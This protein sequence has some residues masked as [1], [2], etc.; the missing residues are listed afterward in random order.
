MQTIVGELKERSSASRAATGSSEE[1]VS[2]SQESLGVGAGEDNGF[3]QSKLQVVLTARGGEKQK[4]PGRKAARL[5]CN[6]QE[7]LREEAKLHHRHGTSNGGV[8]KPGVRSFQADKPSLAVKR[9]R[10]DAP[11]NVELALAE[12]WALTSLRR[13]HPN[14]V[15][16]EEC[17]LQRHGLGQR[18]SHGNKRSQL[19]LRLVETS[20]KGERILGYA[21]EPCYLWFVMEF[22]EGGDLNQY[23]LS[24]RPDPATNRSFML[25]LT[26]AIAFLHKNHIVH[27]DLKPDNILITEKS[28]TPVL[29][30][31]DFGLSKVCAGLTARGKKGGHENKN[32]NV[33]KYWLSSACGSDFYM[34]PEVWEGHY[35]AKADIFALGIII[36]AMIERL[37]FIDA[38]TKR[39]LLGTYIK[40]GTEIVPV[41]EALLE[42]PKMEL[43]IPQKRRTSMSEGI[44][45]LLKDMLAANPQDRPDAFEL[46]T[47]MDQVTC[48]A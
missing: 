18:M 38:E 29:K 21:E 14:V 19:Y 34:A 4:E 31:A 12:F 23:V 11:E 1:L 7:E 48:A 45:Q 20:L 36:W 37:T 32:V 43:H 47:R 33:N 40:Q 13:Q 26:S 35:T 2:I 41:G 8:P 42:N 28:G 24:R 3:P 9:I 25:Q 46:E 6:V 44:K 30:V 17:V 10:C 5:L 15:R 27:R 22:C 16:F 39:E